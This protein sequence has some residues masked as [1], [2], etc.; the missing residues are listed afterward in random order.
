[1][2]YR[3]ALNFVGLKMTNC[4]NWTFDKNK[5]AK[6]FSRLAFYH[7]RQNSSNR[8]IL[9]FSGFHPNVGKTFAV[10]TSTVWKVLKKAIVQLN[11]HQENFC[12]LLKI[13]ENCKAFLSL[14]FC[15][16]RYLT[17]PIFV[18]GTTFRQKY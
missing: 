2:G 9:W 1:M 10:S 3:I 4:L 6:V 5:L 14:N 15:Y 16:L 8:K 11:I 17:Q 7:K 12:G 13:P 18:E